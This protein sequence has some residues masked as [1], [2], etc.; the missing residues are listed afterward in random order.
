MRMMRSRRSTRLVPLL[1][2][3]VILA[4]GIA[5]GKDLI[6]YWEARQEYSVM[7]DQLIKEAPVDSDVVEAA[8]GNNWYPDLDIDYEGY[9]DI[10]VDFVG[11]LYF[12]LLDI[13]YPVAI[14][15]NNIEYL[16]TT[17]DGTDNPSGCIFMDYQNQ[18]NWKD[19]NTYIY[20][21]NM[22][23]RS[24]FGTLKDLIQNGE[25]VRSNPYIYIY[26]PDHIMRYQ[27]FCVE[28]APSNSDFGNIHRDSQYDIYISEIKE[29]AWYWDDSMDLSDRPNIL[30]LY[31]CYGSGHTQKLLVHAALIDEQEVTN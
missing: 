17:F 11:V 3:L 1:L 6:T 21:H 16:T 31:T 28:I 22:R 14:S 23:D 9:K 19:R 29:R 30:T 10:N 5:A 25:L 4:C 12:P 15:N 7:D 26:T 24:M 2:I 8:S 27:V 18:R 13:R 20:G